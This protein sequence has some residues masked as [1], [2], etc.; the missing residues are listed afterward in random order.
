MPHTRESSHI[1]RCPEGWRN[2]KAA[3]KGFTISSVS[4]QSGPS[5]AL[6]VVS[7][8]GTCSS[9]SV[10]ARDR[11]N[12]IDLDGVS[13]N[14]PRL[15]DPLRDEMVEVRSASGGGQGPLRHR[16]G[17]GPGP[18]RVPFDPYIATRRH[19]HGDTGD[20]SRAHELNHSGSWGSGGW[21][22]LSARSRIEGWGCGRRRPH[23]NQCLGGL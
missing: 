15:H 3:A 2:P 21:R 23:P 5:G 12:E 7:P 11:F 20:P 18:L 6:S 14:K 8:P 1:N 16:P 10:G 22:A 4:H 19:S 17:P 13:I 9:S